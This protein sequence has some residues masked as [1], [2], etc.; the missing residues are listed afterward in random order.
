MLTFVTADET[1]T[2]VFLSVSKASPYQQHLREYLESL[3]RQE[4]TRPGWCVIG[5]TAGEPTARAALWALPGE[6]VPSDVVLIDSDWSEVDLSSGHVLLARVHE[7]A[8]DLGADGLSHSV[9]S[10][11]GAPQYQDDEAARIQLREGRV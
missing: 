11:P 10:P 3:L 1:S 2:D 4:C 6:P 9:D 5:L 8:A 7:L